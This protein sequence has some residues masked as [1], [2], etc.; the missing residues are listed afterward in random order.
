MQSQIPDHFIFE[1]TV[2]FFNKDIV[3]KGKMANI[4][5]IIHIF[6][7][8]NNILLLTNNSIF[9]KTFVLHF[10]LVLFTVVK[11]DSGRIVAKIIIFINKVYFSRHSLHKTCAWYLQRLLSNIWGKKYER[12]SKIW[13]TFERNKNFSIEN[14]RSLSEKFIWETI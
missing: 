8:H 5:E 11:S 9:W 4:S 6:K 3:Y 14:C 1:Y 13:S 12:W 2:V 10:A 7:Y